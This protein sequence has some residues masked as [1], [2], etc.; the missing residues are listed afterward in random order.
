M[1]SVLLTPAGRGPQPGT[2]AATVPG[3]ADR[4]ER[5]PTGA[6][7]TPAVQVGKDALLG[8]RRDPKGTHGARARTLRRA[9]GE[10]QEGRALGAR[11]LSPP[12]R[13]GQGQEAGG[14]WLQEDSSAVGSGI[15]SF[16]WAGGLAVV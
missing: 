8:E 5:E 1:S 6:A 12:N 13:K 11:I 10:E 9:G 14:E 16:G 4:T 3:R 2:E 7:G 15:V